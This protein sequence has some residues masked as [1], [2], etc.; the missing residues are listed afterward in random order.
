MKTKLIVGILI[1]ALVATS[2]G[3]AVARY[4][5]ENG[6]R[7]VDADNDGVCDNFGERPGFVDENGDGVCDNRGICGFGGYGRN[8]V[9]VDGDGIC[10]NFGINGRD[11]D[12]GGIP[13]GQD[14]DYVPPRDGSGKQRGN[15]H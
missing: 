6:S 12:G 3:V 11:T 4:G 7:H 10:D 14:D 1:A 5:S 9:D 13:N 15:R 2:I 8:F